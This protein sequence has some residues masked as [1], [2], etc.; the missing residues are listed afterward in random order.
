[1]VGGKGELLLG[2]G[3]WCYKETI[4]A[5][6]QSHTGAAVLRNTKQTK[7]FIIYIT[8]SVLLIFIK[9]STLT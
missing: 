4:N 1:M 9:E 6:Q 5:R 7:V 8:T 3:G 2:T